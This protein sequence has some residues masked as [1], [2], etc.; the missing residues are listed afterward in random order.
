[1]PMF[2]CDAVH[3]QTPENPHFQAIYDGVM[4]PHTTK[5]PETS[6]CWGTRFGRPEWN[7]A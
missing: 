6:P 1:M 7:H 5:I 4:D 2:F 3:I